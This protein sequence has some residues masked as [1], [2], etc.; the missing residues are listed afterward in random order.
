MKIGMKVRVLEGPSGL[1]HTQPYGNP[2]DVGHVSDID[3]GIVSYE[4]RLPNGD[5]VFGQGQHIEVTFPG[6]GSWWYLSCSL[7]SAGFGSWYREHA[8]K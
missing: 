6:E 3:G 1:K 5:F 8:N 7:I 4:R 2:G